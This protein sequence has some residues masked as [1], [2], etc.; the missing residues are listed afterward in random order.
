MVNFVVKSK[1]LSGSC[2]ATILCLILRFAL[3]GE[4]GVFDIVTALKGFQNLIEGENTHRMTVTSGG[5]L[6]SIHLWGLILIVALA[7]LRSSQTS[8]GELWVCLENIPREQSH[9]RRDPSWMC[10]EHVWSAWRSGWNKKGRK[11]AGPAHHRHPPLLS[12]SWPQWGKLFS[13]VLF[14][15][16][17][18][19]SGLWNREQN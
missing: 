10:T 17:W 15:T 18:L 6:D 11:E 3:W 14:P 2:Q 1:C 8:E 19:V 12:P 7:G 9:R 13:V 4:S 5:A 16:R